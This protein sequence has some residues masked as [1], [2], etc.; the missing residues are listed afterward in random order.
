MSETEIRKILRHAEDA[1]RATKDAERWAQAVLHDDK[2][3]HANMA[4]RASQKAN[5]ELDD[6]IRKLKALLR[7]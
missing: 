3:G 7:A 5:R 1:L 4:W 2:S 6:V